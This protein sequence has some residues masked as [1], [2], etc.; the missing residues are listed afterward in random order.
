MTTAH[1]E[2]QAASKEIDLMR[3]AGQRMANVMY[4][5]AQR[6]GYTLT[7]QDATNLRNLHQKWD[8]AAARRAVT[9]PS[10]NEVLA[11]A[12]RHV[13][14]LADFAYEQGFHELGYDPVAEITAA[15]MQQ[16]NAVPSEK[17]CTCPSGDGSLR[18]PCPRHADECGIASS[19]PET[20]KCAT[21]KDTGYYADTFV[22]TESGHE[23]VLQ[24]C[25]CGGE[26]ATQLV[27]GDEH[28]VFD[29]FVRL[30]NIVKVPGYCCGT[31]YT[32]REAFSMALA[33]RPIHPA[34]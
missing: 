21:C 7:D 6:V 14:A 30:R 4:N 23:P 10:R 34:G 18:W 24:Q 11:Q 5:M 15:L 9:Q 29:E 19:A 17:P 33:Q 3:D 2:T 28:G 13:K 12:L 16:L 8:A 20:P 32:E 26:P 1:V 27:A 25:D 31:K 22:S